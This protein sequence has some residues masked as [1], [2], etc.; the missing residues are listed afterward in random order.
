MVVNYQDKKFN[1]IGHVAASVPDMFFYFYFV[2][3]YKIGNDSITT[4]V[5]VEISTFLELFEFYRFFA[6]K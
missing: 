5:R 2:K 1:N 4:E 6:A 3:N